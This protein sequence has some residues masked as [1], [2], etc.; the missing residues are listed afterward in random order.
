MPGPSASTAEKNKP[1]VSVVCVTFNSADCLRY[2]LKSLE[3]LPPDEIEIIFVDNHSSDSSVELIRKWGRASLIIQNEQNGGWSAA[4]NQ[5]LKAAKGEF[6][7]LA[8]PDIWFEPQALRDL[9]RFLGERSEFAAAAPQL[10]N[11]D[12][13]IQPSFRRLPT[14]TDLVFQITGLAFLFPQSFSLFSHFV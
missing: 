9:V 7:L 10:L 6:I 14:L 11:P 12:G 5:G 3:K 1:K 2:L 13:S 8:N 4:N